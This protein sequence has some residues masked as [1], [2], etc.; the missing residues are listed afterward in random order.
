MAVKAFNF[1]RF[2]PSLWTEQQVAQTSSAGTPV[3][4]VSEDAPSNS[5]RTQL[6]TTVT[7]LTSP[8]SSFNAYTAKHDTVAWV[9]GAY[10]P[11]DPDSEDT[12]DQCFVRPRNF[13]IFEFR[14]NPGQIYTSMPLSE[15]KRMLHRYQQGSALFNPTLTQRTIN[16]RLL[17]SALQTN[18]ALAV[19]INGYELNNVLL[20]TPVTRLDVDAERTRDNIE[21]QNAKTR[22][23]RM[24]FLKFYVQSNGQMVSLRVGENGSVKFPH[25][26]DEATALKVF[27]TLEPIIDSCSEIV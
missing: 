9:R 26:P 7:P 1:M 24:R 25:Y 4:N 21:I 27:E 15:I 6:K 2:Q 20:S 12:E 5:D 10:T 18:P 3:L 14:N 8:N 16:L 13:P 22:A 19:V 17:E 11:T 23:E